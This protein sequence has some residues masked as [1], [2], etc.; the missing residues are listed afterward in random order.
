MK[1]H[2]KLPLFL[3]DLRKAPNDAKRERKV[4]DFIMRV[5]DHCPMYVLLEI[6][7]A[8]AQLAKQEQEIWSEIN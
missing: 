8:I 2:T 3:D 4:R 7:R 5:A 1:V 6:G